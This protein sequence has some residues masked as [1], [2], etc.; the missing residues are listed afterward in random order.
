MTSVNSNLIAIACTALSI[1]VSI[2]LWLQAEPQPGTITHDAR[3]KNTIVEIDRSEEL[4]SLEPNLKA[5]ALL[6]SQRPVQIDLGLFGLKSTPREKADIGKT[7]TV[8][9]EINKSATL[10]D[11]I[12][13]PSQDSQQFECTAETD[14][15]ISPKL[16]NNITNPK[17][18]KRIKQIRE[19]VALL[20]KKAGLSPGNADA[21][22][23]LDRYSKMLDALENG[24]S[25]P[26]T[27]S[28]Q[29]LDLAMNALEMV[30]KSAKGKSYESRIREQVKI[31]REHI[32]NTR[33]RTEQVHAQ[34]HNNSLSDPGLTCLPA[35][36]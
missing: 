11:F 20:R 27:A 3:S 24:T 15:L 14:N 1:I 5:I 30:L 4:D 16:K 17:D 28:N 34:I 23:L 33:K 21:S 29:S 19:Q 10:N 13:L 2:Y 36:Q 31:L 7:A 35:V 9:P 22:A 26:K 32:A 25:D 8:E 18:A 6:P 12:G